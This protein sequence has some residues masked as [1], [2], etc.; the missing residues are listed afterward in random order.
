MST[1]QLCL[2]TVQFGMNYGIKNELG[3][4][5]TDAEAFAVLD[6]A[7]AAGI[8]SF[9]TARAYGT[10]EEVLGR[11]GLAARD[12]VQIISKLH[13]DLPDDAEAVLRDIETSLDRLQTR[14]LTCLM[15]HRASDMDRPAVME[16]VCRARQSGLTETLGVSVYEPEEAMRAL[17]DTRFASIQIPYN[18]LDRRLDACGFFRGAKER[19]VRVYARSAFLQGLLLME[20]E[21]A[22]ARVAGSGALIRRFSGIAGKYGFTPAEA[23]MLYSLTH[24]G[25]DYV[26][27]GVDTAAQLADNVEIRKKAAQFAPCREE[28]RGAFDEVAREIIVPSLW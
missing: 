16:G 21:A 23:A 3:R 15:L 27:F 25:I 8:R 5:P 9:D 11:Y 17:E 4:R 24:P 26:V 14:K 22:Q 1:A 28:L 10:A 18:V 7:L 2:G 20:P 6:A 19:Q 12:G 13:P